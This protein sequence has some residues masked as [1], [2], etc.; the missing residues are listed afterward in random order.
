MAAGEDPAGV[1][2]S[3]TVTSAGPLCGSHPAPAPKGTEDET[4]CSEKGRGHRK[5]CGALCWPV[6]PSHMGLDTTRAWSQTTWNPACSA[7]FSTAFS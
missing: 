1:T 7:L 5:A 6:G 2:P 4:L 3:S